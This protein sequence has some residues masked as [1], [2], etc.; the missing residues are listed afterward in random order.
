M[1]RRSVEKVNDKKL[2]R[3]NPTIF[4]NSFIG[5]IV[6]IPRGQ[7]RNEWFPQHIAEYVTLPELKTL[8][9]K[10]VAMERDFEFGLTNLVKEA[11]TTTDAMAPWQKDIPGDIKRLNPEELRNASAFQKR[12]EVEK[13][14]PE[15]STELLE[16]FVG[17]RLEFYRQPIVEEKEKEPEVPSREPKRSARFGSGAAADLLA[18][19]MPEPEKLKE[20]KDRSQ[21][22]YGSVS[23]QDVLMA[24]RAAMADNDEAARVVLHEQDISFADLPE[25]EDGEAGK[26]KHTGDFSVDIKVKGSDISIR[27]V[28]R[29]IPQDL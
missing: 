1:S 23:T 20:T 15:R 17:P 21:A 26:L 12:A 29:V 6:P 2:V 7:M 5:A 22:I 4:A 8:R 10:N 13:L 24:L 19:R 11:S 28:V 27:R 14:T 9:L 3:G 18:A 25:A 16:I